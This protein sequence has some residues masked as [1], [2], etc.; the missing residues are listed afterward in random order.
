MIFPPTFVTQWGS[1]SDLYRRHYLYNIYLLYMQTGH[2][3]LD[4]RCPIYLNPGVC[5][6]EHSYLGE[7]LRTGGVPTGPEPLRG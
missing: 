5:R 1:H 4:G 7:G 2:A 3:A 6:E